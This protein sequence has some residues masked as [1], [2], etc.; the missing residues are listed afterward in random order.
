MR[1]VVAAACAAQPWANGG[2]TTR[3]LALAPAAS[4]EPPPA[5]DWRLSLADID[6][7]GPF[8]RLPGVDRVFALVDGSLSLAFDGAPDR[9]PLDAHAE[10]LAFDGERAPHAGPL[11]GTR[12]RALNLM[13]ARGRRAGAMRRLRLA[14]GESLDAGW[15]RDAGVRA[16]YVVAGRLAIGGTTVEAGA[17]VELEAGDPAPVATLP[18]SV[19]EVAIRPACAA[20]PIPETRTPR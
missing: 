3:D 15:A 13:L 5:F 18:A 11:A 10:P 17:L 19:L 12:C 20:R 1:V 2:G 6:R 14:V 4:G 8:S 7:D 16:C 9:V